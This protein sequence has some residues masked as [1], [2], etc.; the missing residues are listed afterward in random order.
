VRGASLARGPAPSTVLGAALGAL[1][2]RAP[3]VTSRLLL[4]SDRAAGCCSGARP[5]S[6]RHAAPCAAAP[7]LPPAISPL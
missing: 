4:V 7:D 2:D 5:P 3:A 1:I 6:S